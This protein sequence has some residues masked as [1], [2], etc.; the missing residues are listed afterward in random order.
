MTL[1]KS[2]ATVGITAHE[3]GTVVVVQGPR[4][5]T[6]AEST[7]FRSFGWHAVN[8]TQYPEVA[9]ARELGMCYAGLAL[10]TDYD[11][12]VEGD[13]DSKPVEMH[14]VFATLKSNVNNTRALL[15]DALPQMA[16]APTCACADSLDHGPL[17]RS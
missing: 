6:R 4:F 15:K 7:W 14:D 5:S 2:A 16:G 3:G 12:G 9:L 10:I 13:A 1:A 11:T 8:M 17:R